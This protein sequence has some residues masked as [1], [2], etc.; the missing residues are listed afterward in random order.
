MVNFRDEIVGRC[1][2]S[3]RVLHAAAAALRLLLLR[4]VEELAE[5]RGRPDSS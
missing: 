3:M 2:G 1:G 4:R 5:A